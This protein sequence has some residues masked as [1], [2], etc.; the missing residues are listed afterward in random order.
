MTMFIH[1]CCLRPLGL[2]SKLNFNISKVVFW[3]GHNSVNQ[4]KHKANT[5]S[6]RQARE[7]LYER[8][9]IAF[10]FTSDWMKKWS[11]IYFFIQ[12][13]SEGMQTQNNRELLLT[14]K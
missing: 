5:C 14:R 2:A 4:S 10:G 9:T 11:G 13:F 6:R 1:F 7:N 3:K 8:G 12:S